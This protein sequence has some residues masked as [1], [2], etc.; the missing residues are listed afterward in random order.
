M[1]P[2][3]SYALLPALL[4]PTAEDIETKTKP[5]YGRLDHI[6]IAGEMAPVSTRTAE[7]KGLAEN[8][9]LN[10]RYAIVQNMFR[11]ILMP[12]LLRQS[13]LADFDVRLADGG[14]PASP[15]DLMPFEQYAGWRMGMPLRYLYIRNNIYIER[16]ESTDIDAFL[17]R[18]SDAAFREDPVLTEIVERTHARVIRQID[19]DDQFMTGYTVS[20][21]QFYNDAVVVGLTITVMDDELDQNGHYTETHYEREKYIYDV[22]LPDLQKSVEESWGHAAVLISRVRLRHT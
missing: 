4:D 3:P 17:N 6:P 16:L 22:V 10:T 20:P 21:I 1:A 7:V 2:N 18:A 8:G 19:S 13:K 12:Y 11:A 14:I 9:H 5:P 15:P